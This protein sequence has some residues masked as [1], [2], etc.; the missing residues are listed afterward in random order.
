M[1]VEDAGPVR[2]VMPSDNLVSAQDEIKKLS[3]TLL[4]KS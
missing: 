3:K 4:A 1:V 2:T